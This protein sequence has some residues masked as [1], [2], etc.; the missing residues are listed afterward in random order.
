VRALD[1]YRLL[2]GSFEFERTRSFIEAADSKPSL[3]RYAAPSLPEG[4]IYRTLIVCGWKS[5]ESLQVLFRKFQSEIQNFIVIENDPDSISSLMNHPDMQVVIE[6]PRIRFLFRQT[7]ETLHANLFR[8]L[9]QPHFSEY[10]ES[11]CVVF[12]EREVSEEELVFYK[13]KV[14]PIYA[15]TCNHIYHNYGRID[16][17]IEGLRATFANSQRID[18]L[19]GIEDLKGIYAGKPA[20][21]IGAGPS[22]DLELELLREHQGKFAIFA[23]DA[24]VKPL[25]KAGITPHF[26]TSI[27]RSN[28]W[29]KAF[30][31]DLP[32]NL[33]TTLVA[34]PVVHPEVLDLYPG[35]MRMVY[36][37]YSYYAYFENNWPKGILHSGGSTA[38]LANR[39]A[40]YMGCSEVI[41]VGID[42]TYE[43][44]K[45]KPGHYRSH[46]NHCG[47][48]EWAD[49][50][51]LEQ[52]KHSP[53]F[54][55]KA[56]DGSEVMTNVTYYQWAKEFAEELVSLGRPLTSTAAKGVPISGVPFKPL[57][58]VVKRFSRIE[59][60][61]FPAYP[62]QIFNRMKWDHS[63]LKSCLKGW[64]EK[65][66]EAKKVVLEIDKE[67]P[68]L[69]LLCFLNDFYKQTF[70]ND[71]FFIGF[72]VQNCAAE[73]YRIQNKWHSLPREPLSHFKERVEIFQERFELFEQVLEK[74]DSAF[75]EAA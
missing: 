52:F 63:Y 18:T 65:A 55:I 12:N 17:S 9:K 72:I 26:T 14:E 1:Y 8:I 2:V 54:P 35:P 49:F 64:L 70:H 67:K 15:E 58:E 23:V 56:Y 33:K 21:L 51:P 53:V 24:A 31:T 48:E 71:D 34:F 30:W 36:R 28:L 13:T 45:E 25:L 40:H 6:N 42:S 22:L 66:R 43:E 7:E 47:H 4:T 3:A 69:Q 74:L 57:E 19:P 11:A 10:M 46:A 32:K 16:D 59:A 27:E 50:K 37:N 38:H 20:L 62:K 73:F 61:L 41:L 39:L 5:M 75:Q 44:S 60:D 68:D 29:Q